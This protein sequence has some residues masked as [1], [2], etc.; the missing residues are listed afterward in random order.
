[1][2]KVMKFTKDN[3][4]LVHQTGHECVLTTQ[5]EGCDRPPEVLSMQEFREYLLEYK[6]SKYRMPYNANLINNNII[7]DTKYK[8]VKAFNRGN[9]A[10]PHIYYEV[11]SNTGK[12]LIL[13]NGSILMFL[14]RKEWITDKVEIHMINC[15]DIL[16]HESYQIKTFKVGSE[17]SIN[18]DYLNNTDYVKILKA[19]YQNKKLVQYRIVHENGVESIIKNTE[20]NDNMY[21]HKM[22]VTNAVQLTE[23]HIGINFKGSRDVEK[24]YL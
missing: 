23:G 12:T 21:I 3:I 13:S 10:F 24:I 6:D 17:F 2:Y 1:M 4:T 19:I 16:R 8:I 7:M 5:N 9:E 11:L 18:W 20:L 15:T 14:N 22:H